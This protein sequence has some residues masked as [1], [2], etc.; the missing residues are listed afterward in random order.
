MAQFDRWKARE[1]SSWPFQVFKKYGSELDRMYWSHITC[2]TY[3]YSKLGEKAKWGDPVEQHFKFDIKYKAE[4]FTN[5]KSWSNS[6]NQFDNWVNLNCTMALSSNLEVYM[7]SAITLALESDIGVLFGASKKIDGVALLKYGQSS[8]IDLESHIIAC[9]KGD[10]SSRA[11]AYENIF[12]RVPKTIT[13]NISK[14]E[15]IRKLR[16]KV[17]HAFGRDIEQARKH[18]ARETLPIEKLSREKTIQ[19]QKLVWRVAKAIDVHLMLGHIGEYQVVDFYHRLY[20]SLR[21]DIHLGERARIFR[22]KLGG[23]GAMLMGKEFC[24]GLVSY[25]EAL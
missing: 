12:G 9:T 8:K 5:I 6:F 14:L 21:K 24:K 11:A 23:F 15:A 20:P 1:A 10:W 13:K 16:N 4:L 7:A 3:V 17:G 25:Y 19:Y 2:S 22:K 18:G